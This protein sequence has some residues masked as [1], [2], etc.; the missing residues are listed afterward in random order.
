MSSPDEAYF[1]RPTIPARYLAELIAHTGLPRRRMLA[2]AGLPP[3]AC[4]LRR[5]RVSVAQ[6]ERLYAVVRDAADD[7]MFGFLAGRAPRGTYALAMRLATGAGE[8]AA[9]F[10]SANRLYAL[11]DRGHHYWSVERAGAR[12]V[13][14][15][16]CRTAAQ[17]ASIFFVHS[18]LLTPWRSAAWLI[19]Q[20]IPLR[21]VRL[22][23]RFARFAAETA[24]LFG[25]EPALVAGAVELELDAAWLAARIARTPADAD[26]YVRTSLRAMLAAPATDTLEAALRGALAHEPH[27]DLASV[28]RALGL[29]RATLA[30]RLAAR[31]L[32]FQRVKDDL[33]RDHAIALLARAPVAEVAAALGFSEPSAFARAFK[34]WTGVP[35]GHYRPAAAGDTRRARARTPR[36]RP[37]APRRAR[38]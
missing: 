28:A 8:L 33:R 34:S 14:R 1:V 12:A 2:A 31:G 19:G 27:T 15:I 22:D 13:L 37:G 30:R 5:F 29:S 10:E 16:A 6:F 36:T 9:F 20:P 23:P 3:D 18:M 35:P 32:T 11:F 7:E 26:A 24:F 25:C 21:A 17:A 38:S 4:A